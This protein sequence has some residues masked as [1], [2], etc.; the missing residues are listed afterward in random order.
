MPTFML[1]FACTP[2]R[3]D[4]ETEKWTADSCIIASNVEEA[5]QSARELIASRSYHATELIAFAEVAEE[6]ISALGQMEATLYLKAQQNSAH[7][8]AV[9]SQWHE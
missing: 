7:R 6:K 3:E 4:S 8:A 2:I 1:H 9:F 5:E